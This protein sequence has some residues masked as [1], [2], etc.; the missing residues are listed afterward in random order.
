MTAL[1]LIV[2]LF[3]SNPFSSTSPA[4]NPTPPRF[5]GGGRGVV[6]SL[7]SEKGGG[8]GVVVSPEPC[9]TFT[10]DN[11]STHDL[12]T[13]TVAGSGY[14]TYFNVSTTGFYQQE[15]CYTAMTVTVAG[16]PVSYPTSGIVDL[17][18]STLVKVIWQS[19][20]LVEVVNTDEV[21]CKR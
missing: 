15:L 9:Y 13:V 16:V 4:S 1:L 19:S 3:T 20:S 18:N 14:S 11:A 10:I 2:S 12:G 17:G 6:N 7:S 5:H 21:G 8:W